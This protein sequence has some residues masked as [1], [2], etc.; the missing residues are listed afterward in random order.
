MEKEHLHTFQT[1]LQLTL[2][3]MKH[4]SK[5][6]S[7]NIISLL[8]NG[9]SLRQIATQLGVSHTTVMRER[10][11][12]R[13][14]IQKR[15][16]G[17]PTKLTI[18]D[19]RQIIRTITSGKVDTAVQLVQELRTTTTTHVGADTIRRSLKQA[20]MKAITK[21][22]KPRLLPRHIR[23]RLDFA[24]CH[25]H[26]TV[27]DWKRVIWSDETKINRLGS[28]GRKW[29]WKK[30]GDNQLADRHVQGTVKFG[31]GSLMLWGC[32][33]A[34]GVGYTCRID[35][36]MDAEVY[37]GILDDYL[38]PTIEYYNLDKDTVIFQQDNDPK[39]TS[40]KAKKCLSDMGLMVLDWPAQSPDLNPI[41]HLWTHLKRK[42]AA[43]ETPPNGILQ[44]WE[45]V[46]E[47]WDKI[48]PEV[49]QGLIES[50]PRCMEALLKAKGG[51]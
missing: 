46:Q 15:Q 47:E 21:K 11:K 2:F 29:A 35:R 36:R 17:R 22:K 27:E 33:T 43:Y 50:M 4:I 40:K 30:R 20:G 25:Q 39:H 24:L 38:L 28:D 5:E 19:K 14:N 18:T 12:A 6:I 44:L 16:G 1:F 26:W 3:T 13:P 34:Q 10:M 7:N 23:Q 41:E 49:C 51:Y 8:D 42:L 48:E 37:T 9:L 45:R 31:G 32:M